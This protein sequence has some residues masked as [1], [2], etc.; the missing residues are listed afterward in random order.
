MIVSARH[1]RSIGFRLAILGIFIGAMWLVRLVDWLVGAKRSAFF[2]VIPRTSDGLAGIA[3]APFVH[4]DWEHLVAN[5]IPLVIM[6]LIILIGGA[7]QFLVVTFVVMLVSGLGMWLFGA[8]GTQH[9]GA[10][11]IVFGFM[12]FLLFRSVFDKRLWSFVTTL[13]VAVAYGGAIGMAVIPEDGVSWVGHMFGFAGGIAAAY[14]LR[15]PPTRKELESEMGRVLS[16]ASRFE[17]DH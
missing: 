4:G 13:F 17:R 11:G 2:G 16:S 10:S 9:I 14:L 15:P 8:P 1:D 7:N 6:G 3:A 5:S 12:S